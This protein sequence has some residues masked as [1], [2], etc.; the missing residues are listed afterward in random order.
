MWALLLKL[1][2]KYIAPIGVV[3]ALALCVRLHIQNNAR[4]DA[5]AAVARMTAK[6]AAS[7][8]KKRMSDK[9]DAAV[10]ILALRD[11]MN[12]AATRRVE[13]LGSARRQSEELAVELTGRQQAKL[14]SI[15]YGYE[16][17]IVSL[18]TDKRH[19]ETIIKLRESELVSAELSIASLKRENEAINTA[20][21]AES[22]RTSN[23]PWKIATGVAAVVAIT[24]GIVAVAK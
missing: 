3:I 1:P 9:T 8:E 21:Q 7:V 11:S 12:K 16:R 22:R 13:N 5:Y 14:D 23:T 4:A 17:T 10:T 19:L 15:R 18:E 2:W 24:T 20:L 6:H